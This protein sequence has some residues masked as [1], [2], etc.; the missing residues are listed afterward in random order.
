MKTD[1]AFDWLKVFV[2]KIRKTIKRLIRRW[3]FFMVKI[4]TST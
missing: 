3:Y 2:E 1:C 4:Y